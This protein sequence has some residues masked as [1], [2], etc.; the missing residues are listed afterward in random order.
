[1]KKILFLGPYRQK[2]SWGQTARNYIHALLSNN[3]IELSTRPIYYTKLIE[4]EINQAIIGAEKTNNHTYDAIIQYGL[5]LALNTGYNN[6]IGIITV[7]FNQAY[8]PINSC[9]LN[10]LKTIIVSTE[11]EKEALQSMGIKKPISVIP[12]PIDCTIISNYINTKKINFS[13]NTINSNFK[14]YCKAGIED[15]HNLKA[16][17]TAFY[18]AFSELDKVSLVIC[19]DSSFTNPSGLKNNIEQL[20]KEIKNILRINNLFNTEIIIPDNYD[21]NHEKNMILHNSCDCYINIS[22]GINYDPDLIIAMY[23]GKTP[24]VMEHTGLSNMTHDDKCGFIVKSTLNPV[25]INQP[26]LPEKYDMFNANYYWRSPNITSLIEILKKTVYTYQNERANFNKKQI[27]GS[28]QIE[29]YTYDSIGD[30]ICRLV[31]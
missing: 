9:T 8:S 25:I 16:L 26:P 21:V 6:N 29:K 13:S 10:R 27:A 14:F 15:R 12:K 7:E 24:I 3:Q 1:M 22:S 18:L 20:S 23:L 28:K 11:T 31:L 19:P 4:Q 5:P 17:I 30:K 2:D